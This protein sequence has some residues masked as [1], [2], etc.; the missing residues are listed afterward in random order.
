MIVYKRDRPELS[1][2]LQK[3]DKNSDAYK[4]ALA[5]I[6]EG[7]RVLFDNPRPDM[8]G[9]QLDERDQKYEDKYESRLEDERARVQ[10]AAK[11]QAENR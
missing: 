6:Q 10:D 8:P 1:P 7:R 3:L 11:A 9:C 5:L 2:C 4:Q